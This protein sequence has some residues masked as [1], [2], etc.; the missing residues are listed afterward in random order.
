MK[1]KKKYL[2]KKYGLEAPKVLFYFPN[3]LFLKSDQTRKFQRLCLTKRSKAIFLPSSFG[4]SSSPESQGPS[5]IGICAKNLG[6]TEMS[7]L[8]S[9]KQVS[10]YVKEKQNFFYEPKKDH[11]EFSKKYAQNFLLSLEIQNKRV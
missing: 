5:I 8:E 11:P 9:L 10:S 6:F 7:L 4:I 3:S 2:K 1:A